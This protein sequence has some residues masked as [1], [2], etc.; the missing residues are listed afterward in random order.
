MY[1]GYESLISTCRL[2]TVHKRI[3]NPHFYP[4]CRSDTFLRNV[5]DHLQNFT[6]SEPRRPPR[7]LRRCRKSGCQAFLLVLRSSLALYSF[8]G[9]TDKFL[10][11]RSY[12]RSHI[13]RFINYFPLYIVKMYIPYTI[14]Q[15]KAV[16]FNE[17]YILC[18]TAYMY[19]I[20]S[21]L[22]C[23]QPVIHFKYFYYFQDRRYLFRTVFWDALPCKMI[24]DRRFRG[25]YCLHHQAVHGSTSHKTI[26]N[27]I[28]AAVRTWNLTEDIWFYYSTL[29]W[30]STGYVTVRPYVTSLLFKLI[31]KLSST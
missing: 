28:L 11:S 17:V 8:I 21:V 13:A 16:G 25:A 27:I 30:N 2:V 23:L 5:A 22:L 31:N 24:V 18:H 9:D 15:M 7:R 6:A 1:T 20:L 12:Y 19:Q 26:L 3:I 14:L 29:W 10:Q 4:A